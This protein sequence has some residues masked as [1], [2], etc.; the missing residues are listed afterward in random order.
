MT[1]PALGPDD[2][3]A[4]W[5]RADFADLL[6]FASPYRGAAMLSMLF[7]SLSVVLSLVAP[8]LYRGL[9]DDGLR[10][11]DGRLLTRYA[12]LIAVAVLSAGV[13]EMMEEYFSCRFALGMMNDVRNRLYRHLNQMTV[14]FF[15]KTSTGPIISRFTSDLLNVQKVVS[16]TLP[17]VVTNVL[18]IGC[19]LAAMLWMSWRLTLITLVAL[20][21]Y[22]AAAVLVARAIGKISGVAMSYGDRLISTLGED[23]SLQGYL[24]FKLWGISPARGQ[25]FEDLTSRIQYTRLQLGMWA[26]GNMVAIDIVQSLGV[27][28]VYYFGGLDVIAGHLSMGTVIAFATIA[29]RLYQP[30]AF[31]S[32][33]FSD[34]PTSVLSMRRIL[35]YLEQPVVPKLAVLSSRDR[36]RMPSP[37]EALHSVVVDRVSFSYPGSQDRPALQEISFKVGSGE[38]VAIVGFNGCGKS[39]LLMVL[40]GLQQPSRGHVSLLGHATEGLQQQDIADLLSVGLSNEFFLNASIRENLRIVKPDATDEEIRRALANSSCE[41]FLRGL[42]EGL[43][44]RIGQSGLQLS[45]GQRQRLSLARMFLRSA[46]VVFLDESTSNLDGHAED[47]VLEALALLPASTTVLFVTHNPKLARR[48]ERVLVLDQGRVIGDGSHGELVLRSARYRQLMGNERTEP[49]G[50]R[51]D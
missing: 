12:V 39:T 7:V 27:V 29:T 15:L 1:D 19:S 45:S 8:M 6:R 34:L 31:F 50:E 17:A 44:T 41:P 11:G 24:F 38:R 13:S 22:S 25:A 9:V 28:A 49:L 21:V 10:H 48:A 3:Q 46:P 18:L 4:T 26:R 30:I 16:R 37:A 5:S 20:P 42:P 43:D 23:F 47:L 32:T 51:V 14:D 2:R 36:S 33:S 35:D 40:A